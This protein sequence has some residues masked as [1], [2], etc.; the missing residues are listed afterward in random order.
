MSTYIHNTDLNNSTHF[1]ELLIKRCE[2][3]FHLITCLQLLISIIVG[4][5]LLNLQNT[6][7]KPVQPVS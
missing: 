6:V 5:M 2:I 3:Q 7:H 4:P 1:A